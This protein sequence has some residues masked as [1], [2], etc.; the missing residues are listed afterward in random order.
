[1]VLPARSRLSAR[2][3]SV[4]NFWVKFAPVVLW[5]AGA[6]VVFGALPCAAPCGSGLR[7]RENSKLTSSHV[8]LRGHDFPQRFSAVSRAAGHREADIALVRGRCCGLGNLSRV[9]PDSA[10]FW[11]RVCGL[12]D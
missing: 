10:A 1:M 8:P 3:E 9:F 2:S 12:D 4:C 7:P 11:L 6:A 5:C